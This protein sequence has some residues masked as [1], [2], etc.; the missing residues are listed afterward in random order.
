M[1]RYRAREKTM[2]TNEKSDWT[3]SAERV[4]WLTDS[5]WSED[6]RTKRDWKQAGYLDR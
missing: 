6:K 5:K 3:L 2:E 4:W 1:G